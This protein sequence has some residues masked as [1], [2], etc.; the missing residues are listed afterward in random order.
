MKYALVMVTIILRQSEDLIATNDS[1]PQEGKQRV[2]CHHCEMLNINGV[3]C[4][5]G[6]CRN[7]HKGWDPKTLPFDHS[8]RP[9]RKYGEWLDPKWK[10]VSKFESSASDQAQVAAFRFLNRNSDCQGGTQSK[11]TLESN[12]MLDSRH[13]PLRNSEDAGVCESE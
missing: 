11:S 13:I 9:V 12:E 4:H 6:S 1:L 8:R 5:E 3:L 7:E 10:L 2:R